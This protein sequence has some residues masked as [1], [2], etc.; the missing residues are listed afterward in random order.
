[1]VEAFEND[2]G[3]LS[4]L[5]AGVGT[6]LLEFK[7]LTAAIRTRENIG[8][9][10]YVIIKPDLP[11]LKIEQQLELFVPGVKFDAPVHSAENPE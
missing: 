11:K 1:M 9:P 3:N 5:L 8:I 7:D 10:K 2:L 6:S 4:E